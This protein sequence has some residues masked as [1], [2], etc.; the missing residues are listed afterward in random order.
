MQIKGDGRILEMPQISLLI[1]DEDNLSRKGLRKML[2]DLNWFTEIAEIGTYQNI[3]AR[4]D[5]IVICNDFKSVELIK[6]IRAK[7]AHQ[8][9]IVL[10]LHL[11][12]LVIAKLI[13]QEVN[14]I[15]L[16]TSPFEELIKCIQL[17]AEDRDFFSQEV[18]TMFYHLWANNKSL[19]EHMEINFSKRETEVL[20]AIC[21][22][23]TNDEIADE[24][25]LSQ[26]SVK[27][28]RCSLLEKTC[29]KT[30]AGL[31]IYAVKHGI[32]KV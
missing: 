6:E 29:S 4:Y 12:E 7:D 8:K 10:L 19:K 3:E 30:S 13:E 24:L 22:Q 15:V 14:G 31:I 27:K 25:F 2:N 16:K 9:I 5:V 11:Q 26:S 20:V 21:N 1:I 32:Y 23:K 28:Y 17:V 18:S